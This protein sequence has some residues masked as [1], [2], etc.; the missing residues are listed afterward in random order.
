MQHDWVYGTNLFDIGHECQIR[1]TNL[2]TWFHFLENM[3]WNNCAYIHKVMDIWLTQ[4]HRAKLII[5][6]F[7][8]CMLE[9]ELLT[10]VLINSNTFHSQYLLEKWLHNRIYC[11]SN[12]SKQIQKTHTAYSAAHNI[13]GKVWMK[14]KSIHASQTDSC[15]LW[16]HVFVFHSNFA[17]YIYCV[18][19][20]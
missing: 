11:P 13:H 6:T 8:V 15:P 19:A 17:V 1:L 5:V 4:S 16:N 12:W 9:C 2:Q 10:V 3:C 20:L 14:K 18:P 7:F